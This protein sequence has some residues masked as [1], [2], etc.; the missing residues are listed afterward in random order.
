MVRLILNIVL[1][2]ILVVFVALNMQYRTAVNIF[3]LALEEVSVVAV[4]LVSLA[5]GIV[6]SFITYL[7]NYFSRLR[8]ERLKK[9]RELTKQKE[10]ELKERERSMVSAERKR[11]SSP[12]EESSTEHEQAPDRSRKKKGAKR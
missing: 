6:Y 8:R 1:L 10:Q 5:V 3:G 12:V 9:N 11:T 4:V 2:V 7:L